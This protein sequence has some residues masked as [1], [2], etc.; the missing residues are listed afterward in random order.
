MSKISKTLFVATSIQNAEHLSPN[1][2]VLSL[3]PYQKAAVD[4]TL[5]NKCS[6]INIPTGAGKTHIALSSFLLKKKK[7]PK[8]RAIVAVPQND[9]GANFTKKYS[10]IF[11]N[12][13]FEVNKVHAL[14]EQSSEGKL[15]QFK[16]WISEYD[17]FKKYCE[18][19]KY[20][21]DY[22]DAV[23]TS[24]SLLV[25]I[26]NQFKDDIISNDYIKDLFIVIDE[27]H[28]VAFDEDS[29]V[30]NQLAKSLN[31]FLAHGA[32]VQTLTATEFRR[33]GVT[34]AKSVQD[35]VTYS[36]SIDETLQYTNIKSITLHLVFGNQ[37]DCIKTIYNDYKIE[38]TQEP[39]KHS[40]IY[41]QNSG[42]MKRGE[43]GD[44]STIKDKKILDIVKNLPSSHKEHL[45]NVIGEN[46]EPYKDLFDSTSNLSKTTK[47]VIAQN[48]MKEGTDWIYN[49]TVIILGLES[50]QTLSDLVQMVGR[51][52]R[53][54]RTGEK[55]VNI[56]LQAD[57]AYVLSRTESEIINA[58]Q[59]YVK[60]IVL[61]M[62][63]I[64]DALP[65]NNFK[66]SLYKEKDHDKV[67][68][69]P[70][71]DNDIKIKEFVDEATAEIV[72]NL[73]QAGFADQDISNLNKYISNYVDSNLEDSLAVHSLKIKESIKEKLATITSFALQ[74]SYENLDINLLKDGLKKIGKIFLASSNSLSEK[75]LALLKEKACRFSIEA[76]EFITKLSEKY[77]SFQLC[78]NFKKSGKMLFKCLS[79]NKMRKRSYDSTN[80]FLK[81]AKDNSASSKSPC[82]VCNVSLANAIADMKREL[83][84]NKSHQI[85]FEEVSLLDQSFSCHCKK[86]DSYF[87]ANKKFFK[88]DDSKCP[89]C[90]KLIKAKK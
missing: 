42:A 56:F 67:T 58:S 59:E 40:I 25:K 89:K 7:N 3:R 31:Y 37:A 24:H 1:S 69:L 86:Q 54:S 39:L 43:S 53:D 6:A 18:D 82:V 61:A 29:D 76:Q 44:I 22:Q 10:Y 33:E 36:V 38:H 52:L 85:E 60:N 2:D 19:A 63:A 57:P 88:T 84:L 71:S 5:N 75:D 65:V 51:S 73:A 4:V 17:N 30:K 8:L 41:L 66:G 20:L 72:N 48:R 13:S 15:N 74:C 64:I 49:D 23:V 55:H 78:S 68:N 45:L 80:A 79:C 90:D 11:N 50:R 83:K 27:A 14:S 21:A 81:H 28:H 62:L 77:S 70:L 35:C 87:I 32:S 34:L 9:I 46:P 26:Y 12:T 16:S 47:V